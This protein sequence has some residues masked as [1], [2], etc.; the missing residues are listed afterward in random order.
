MR[1]KTAVEGSLS[2][3]LHQRPRREFPS[4]PSST[5]EPFV[6][7]FDFPALLPQRSP[8]NIPPILR[9]LKPNLLAS[10]ISPFHCRLQIRRPRRDSQHPPA[11]SKKL[12]IS[13]RSP[14]MKNLHALAHPIQSDNIFPHIKRP[15]ISSRSHHHAHRRVPRPSEIPI[16]YSPFHRSLQRVRKVALQPHQ[17]R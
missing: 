4:T 16:A 13:L 9:P 7:N 8:R 15:R 5:F 2:L 14:R 17:D 6:V 1:S 3:S 11:R 10:R 12:S